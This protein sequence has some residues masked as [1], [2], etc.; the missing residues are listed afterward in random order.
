[1]MELRQKK[2]KNFMDHSSLTQLL[3]ER[4]RFEAKAKQAQAAVLIAITNEKA[5][6]SS[7]ST[8]C[9]VDR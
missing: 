6:T 2:D 7:A 1:M 3:Q 9:I 4:L 5:R 8:S